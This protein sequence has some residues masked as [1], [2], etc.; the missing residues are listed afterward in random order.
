MAIEFRCTQCNKLLRTDD[1]TAGKAARCPACGAVVPIPSATT[2]S[3]GALPPG[4]GEDPFAGGVRPPSVPPD[5]GNP[6]QSPS[7]FATPSAA[8]SGKLD[9]GDVFSRTWILFKSDWGMCLLAALVAFL[10]NLGANMASHFLPVAGPVAAMLF[11]VWINI[12]LALF[13]LKKARR[14]E[15]AVGEVFNG[16][17]YFGKVLLAS[18]LIA[19]I[20]IGIAL[21]CVLPL[22]LIGMAIS[23][24]ATVALAVTGAIVAG[25]LIWYVSLVLS[26]FRYLI[27]D[28]NLGVIESL[29]T[30]KDLMEGN[31]LTL[32]LIGLVGGALAVLLTI[33]TCGVGYLVVLPYFTMMEAVIYLT[34]T[35]QPTAEQMQPGPMN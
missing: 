33:L 3:G 10:L 18:L 15:V 32:F 7:P 8:M 16:G 11:E 23:K 17:P 13:F 5:S 25:G 14:Q 21:V 35:N 4:P 22:V 20:M 24:D 28:R 6:Y 34:I 1:D 19:A 12:G 30:S 27:I 2:G 29:R 31:K 9:L 26:Q